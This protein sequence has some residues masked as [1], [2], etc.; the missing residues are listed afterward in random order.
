MISKRQFRKLRW[1]SFLNGTT[2][3][4]Y[5]KRK[6]LYDYLKSE[7]Y[8]RKDT[9]R[10]YSGYI[11]TEKGYAEMYTYRMEH[12]RFWFPS[13]VSLFALAASVLSLATS[14]PEFWKDAQKAVSSLLNAFRLLP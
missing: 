10:G 13:I 9:V 7:Q 1:I 4:D 5:E 14:N 11:V 8:I 12:F 3:K 6:M 2:A